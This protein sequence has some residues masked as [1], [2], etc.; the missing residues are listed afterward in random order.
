MYHRARRRQSLAR[1]I[2]GAADQSR[3]LLAAQGEAAVHV[4]PRTRCGEDPF[5]T[6]ILLEETPS[7]VRIPKPGDQGPS[8]EA[9]DEGPGPLFRPAP[10]IAKVIEGGFPNLTNDP[11]QSFQVLA[12]YCPVTIPANCHRRL[13]SLAGAPAQPPIQRW[14]GHVSRS[15][16]FKTR[17][18]LGAISLPAPAFSN[19]D[20]LWASSLWGWNTPFLETEN[21][22][23][24]YVGWSPFLYSRA[25]GQSGL[26]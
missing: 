13:P 23:G 25:P 3:Q 11:P 12:L 2:V 16:W 10:F 20:E 19:D 18:G 6:Q 15:F 17:E 26:I 9:I 22:A 21:L 8:G 14:T 4:S 24:L 1:I 5:V 7:S